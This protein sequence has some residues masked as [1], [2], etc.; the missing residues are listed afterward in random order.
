MTQSVCPKCGGPAEEGLCP[1]CELRSTELI[2]SPDRAEVT[3]CSVCGS[4]QIKGKWLLPDT[5]TIEDMASQAACDALWFHKDFEQPKID[6]SLSRR[7]DTRYLARMD[8]QGSFQG[9]AVEEH[10]EI[11]VRIRLVSCDRC[12]RIAGKY[13]QST[14][15]VRG[16]VS[17]PLS[18]GEMEE[19][20]KMAHAMADAAYLGGDQLAF[21]QEI[22]QVKGG[23]DII[24][25]STQLGRRMA[26]S[27]SE[28]FGGKIL[29]SCKLVGKKDNR[30]VYRSTLLIRFPRLKRGDIFYFRGSL[31]EVMG[32]DGKKTLIASLGEGKRSAFGEEDAE[33]VVVLGNKAD[34][35]R[36]M[37]I[38]KE[39]KVLEIMDP[40]TYKMALAV[41]P[42]GLEIEPGEEVMA[43]RTENGFI[44]LK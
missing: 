18:A 31:V 36:A 8:I 37:V 44:V 1:A 15:Q 6:L 2:R 17:R 32:F 38:T 25:G 30:D 28:R 3:I 26:R 27:I 43:V 16:N 7:G 19:S 41:R 9:Q 40:E 13:F 20:K 4:R 10:R 14:V 22:K 39:D 11:P 23:L 35:L 24:L 34:A 42:D 29:E 33:A 12:S 21:I 5:S